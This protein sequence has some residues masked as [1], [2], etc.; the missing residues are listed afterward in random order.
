MNL[1]NLSSNLLTILLVKF[2]YLH[3]FKST[4]RIYLVNLPEVSALKIS[5]LFFV[6]AV[7]ISSYI[8][9]PKL[10]VYFSKKASS[11]SEFLDKNKIYIKIILL[12]IMLLSIRTLLTP[13]EPIDRH[14]RAISNNVIQLNTTDHMNKILIYF[15]E[16]L[17]FQF[18]NISFSLLITANILFL[19][20]GRFKN[21]S[22]LVVHFLNR[23]VDKFKRINFPAKK[24]Y[25]FSWLSFISVYLIIVAV[26][27]ITQYEFNVLEIASYLIGVIVIGLLVIMAVKLIAITSKIINLLNQHLSIQFLGS[28]ALLLGVLGSLGTIYYIV[29]MAIVQFYNILQLSSLIF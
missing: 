24:I 12:G 19:I 14:N 6:L 21:S 26:S 25:S 9:L 2:L 8:I 10:I 4:D 28:L 23:I 3:W 16:N 22:L 18:R 15:D 1:V 13:P 11:F 29:T 5:L 27:W 7:A 17:A 20:I